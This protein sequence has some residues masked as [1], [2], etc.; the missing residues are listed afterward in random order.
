MNLCSLPRLFPR[1]K[2]VPAL[3]LLLFIWVTTPLTANSQGLPEGGSYKASL[4]FIR[5]YLGDEAEKQTRT[6]WL[7]GDLKQ[8]AADILGHSFN[9]LRVRYWGENRRTVWMLDEIGKE[10]PITVGVVV[11]N[12]K[13][14]DIQVLEY[15]ETR[16]GEVRYPF[17]TN[18]FRGLT[19]NPENQDKLNNR[20]DG[21]TGATLSVAAVKKVAILAL[22]FHQHTPLSA[23]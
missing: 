13:L 3:L 8:R 14:L 15:R 11:D 17:F 12:N 4:D 9:G 7:T 23:N 10:L 6:L 22:V 5:T 16:G 1:R 18:Q 21:I 2:T 20:I 19:L